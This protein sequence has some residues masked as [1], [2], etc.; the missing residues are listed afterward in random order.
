MDPRLAHHGHMQGVSS[1]EPRHGI[2]QRLGGSNLGDAE[3]QD[4]VRQC[5]Q[6]R[7][8][9][10]NGVKA[11]DCGI[12]MQFAFPDQLR[13]HDA[14]SVL[15]GVWSARQVHRHIGVADPQDRDDPAARPVRRR[16][17]QAR[18]GQAVMSRGRRRRRSRL[19]GSLWAARWPPNPT[20]SQRTAPNG[21][22]WPPIQRR[23]PATK[24]RTNLPCGS[25]G[26]S[27]KQTVHNRGIVLCTES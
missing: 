26:R 9:S 10:I 13:Q 24:I 1:R 8:C 19:R 22:R 23:E 4:L 15:V 21:S 14:N 7:D 17:T 11:S 2:D 5:L 27:P 6:T 25:L 12:P 16:Q 18:R 3:D 20:P